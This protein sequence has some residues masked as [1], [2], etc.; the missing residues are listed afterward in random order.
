MSDGSDAIVS[1][2]EFYLRIG[3][4]MLICVDSPIKAPLVFKRR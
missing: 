2:T 3:R 4:K 1:I